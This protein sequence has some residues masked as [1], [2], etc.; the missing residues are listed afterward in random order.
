MTRKI[1]RTILLVGLTALLLCAALLC[2]ALV[3]HFTYRVLDELEVEARLAARGVELCG[4][5]YLEGL[6]S[7]NRFTWIDGDGTVLFDSDA[8][9]GAMENH[10]ERQEVRQALLT[11]RG[12][13]SRRS[14]T[15]AA[16]TLY[17]ALALE[18]GTV[19]RV[20]SRIKKASG[21]LLVYFYKHIKSYTQCILTLHQQSHS[22]QASP[23]RS[24][25]LPHR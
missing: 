22:R 2:W 15:L 13:S 17:I 11:G 14:G 23:D 7:P 4:R 8:D 3:R 5:D 9:A 16:R 1:F 12:Q 24:A 20:A 25:P 19:L 6:D 21:N 18:G 10:L